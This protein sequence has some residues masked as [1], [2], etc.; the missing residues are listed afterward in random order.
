MVARGFRFVTVMSD[1]T[2]LGAMARQTVELVR[3]ST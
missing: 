3:K 1:T 2:L